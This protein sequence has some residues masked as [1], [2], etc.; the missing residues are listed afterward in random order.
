V[1]DVGMKR[2]LGRGLTA[3]SLLLL[4][5]ASGCSLGRGAA[6]LTTVVQPFSQEDRL[7]REQA[8]SEARYR[9]RSGD[10][11]RV[12]FKY[13]DGLDQS[14]LL[15]LP[16]GSLSMGGID[17]FP[18][19][20]RTIQ[21]VD[22]ILTE[23]FSAEYRNADL[24]V[25]MQKLGPLEVYVLGEVRKPGLLTLP[26]GGRGVL[27]A[28]AAAGGFSTDAASGETVVIRVTQEGF[29]Y[30]HLDLRHLEKR[31]DLGVSVLDLQPYDIIY[32][33]RSAIGDL[34]YFTKNVLSSV[35]DF[36]ELYWDIYA[37]SNIDKV[38]RIVR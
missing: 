29:Q 22:D 16:D 33:P 36:S 31:H 15:V 14:D 26:E 37:L 6:P 21:E 38:D 18:V 20:G 2:R 7:L 8:A 1:D 23:F 10:V 12:D 17:P 24:S 32:V 34:A 30:N 9:L 11:L 13:E 5:A 25:I 4:V 35:L 3:V 27:Q 19:R 28:V